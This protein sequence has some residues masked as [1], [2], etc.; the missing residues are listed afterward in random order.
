MNELEFFLIVAGLLHFALLPVSLAV[1]KVLRWREELSLVSP[2]TRKVIW[3]HG[4]FIVALIIS[5]GALTL[6]QR[7]RMPAELA[8]LIGGFWLARLLVQLFYY[9]PALWPKTWWARLGRHALTALFAFWTA[10][11]LWAALER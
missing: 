11:Y 9:E 8:G 4:A 5:F 2:L 6:A 3:V 1:P 10:V 7:T